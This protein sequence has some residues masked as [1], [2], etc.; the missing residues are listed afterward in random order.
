MV[1][2]GEVQVWTLKVNPVHTAVLICGDWNGRDVYRQ[3]LEFTDFPLPE[4]TLYY[5]N[6]VIHL[7]SEY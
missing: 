6:N 2:E 1:C 4:V 5:C 3:T 7:P